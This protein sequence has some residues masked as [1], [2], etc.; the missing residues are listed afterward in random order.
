ML[1]HQNF[2]QIIKTVPDRVKKLL[3][4]KYGKN[5]MTVLSILSTSASQNL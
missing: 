4:L 2:K 1:R 3:M 5:F